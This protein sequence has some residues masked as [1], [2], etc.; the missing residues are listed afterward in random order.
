MWDSLGKDIYIYVCVCVCV[1]GVGGGEGGVRFE[2]GIEPVGP[3]QGGG[4]AYPHLSPNQ[5]HGW[6]FEEEERR[7]WLPKEPYERIYLGKCR[8]DHLHQKTIIAWLLLLFFY[9]RWLPFFFLS[10]LQDAKMVA[11]LSKGLFGYRLLLKIEN[12]IVK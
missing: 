8:A 5:M 11:C 4:R 6:E 7:G 12:T 1:C 2:Y 10:N 9:E 3:V